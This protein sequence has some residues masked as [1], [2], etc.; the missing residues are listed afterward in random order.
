MKTPYDVLGVT[1]NASAE[2]IRAAFRQAAKAYHPDHN[3]GD[4]TAEP[5]LRLIIAAYNMVKNPGKRA[6]CDQYLRTIRRERVRHLAAAAVAGLVGLGIVAL[7]LPTT[8][9]AFGSS[10]APRIAAARANQPASQQVAAADDSGGRQDGDG[11]RASDGDR[12]APNGRLP[13]DGTGQPSAGSPDPATVPA[14]ALTPLAREWAQVQASGDPMA[15]W[16]FAVSNPDAPE[17]GLAL[18]RLIPLIDAA[19]ELSVLQDLR[20]AAL[21]RLIP[22]TYPAEDVSVP[23]DR[24]IAAMG[25]IA[26]RA[27]LRLVQL[28]E[29]AVGKGAEVEAGDGTMV[30]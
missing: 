22:L 8:Q 10:H 12:A 23:Q 25:A 14:E 9:Q 19:E 7:V 15:V 11:G 26:E 28:G 21:S 5:Q 29:L 24:R 20:I 27:Q 16:A 6:D 30:V 2:A 4:P 3:A 18:S 1:R 13:D 17:A